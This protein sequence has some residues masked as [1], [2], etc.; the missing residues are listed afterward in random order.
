M[1]FFPIAFAHG[2]VCSLAA[3]KEAANREQERIRQL[4]P[5]QFNREML[6]RQTRALESIANQKPVINVKNSI[7]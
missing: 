2:V 6:L 1:I 7:F 5:E 3:A 4:T